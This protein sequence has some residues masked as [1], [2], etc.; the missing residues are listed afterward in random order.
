MWGNFPAR[1]VEIMQQHAKSIVG[2]TTT[3]GLAVGLMAAA[4]LH[5]ATPAAQQREDDPLEPTNQEAAVSKQETKKPD[6][7]KP[8]K[9]KSDSATPERGTIDAKYR[10]Q[11]EHLFKSDAAW[12]KERKAIVAGFKEIEACKGKL[13][14]GNKMVKTCLDRVFALRQSLEKLA[15][16]A[17]RRYDQ[18]TR[19]A[20][21]QGMKQVTEKVYTDYLEVTSFLQPELLSLPAQRL[22][23]MIK[24]KAFSDYDQFLRDILRL[25]PHILSPPEE[26]L[27]ASASLM[28]D[29]GY[30]TYSTFSGADLTFP[31]V[32]DAEGN[33]VQLTQALFT[34]YR[35]MADRRVRKDTFEA[36][37]STYKKYR[38][39]LASLLGSQINANI[40]YAKA[41]KY[42]SALEASLDANN[43][44]TAVYHNMV[45]AVN[46]HLPTLHRYLKLRQELLG[47]KDLYYYDMYPP[48]VKEV[49]LKFSYDEGR[50]LLG[51][52]L[53]PMGR[54]Y[55]DAIKKGMSPESGWVDVYPNKGK[56]S[57]AYMDGSA[58][59][60]HPFVLLNY[61]DNYNSVS[62]LAHEMGHAMHSYYSNKNQ[63]FAKADYSIFV[64]EVASTLNEAL[65]M[66]HMLAQV[67]DP[68]KRLYLLG[69]Q[70][71]D[72]RQTVFR[73]SMF[74][75]F[76][77]AL[78]QR[79]EKKEPLTSDAISKIYLEIA[80]KYYGHDKGI[81][82]VDDLYG[83]EW[84]YV[85]HFYYN[86]Y[87]FQ[88]VTGMTAATAL[89][90]MIL[91]DKQGAKA[92]ERYVNH[93]LKKGSSDYSIKLLK[94]AGVDLT[95]TK[96]YDVAMAV[97]SRALA[98]AE[99]LVKQRKKK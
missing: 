66:S 33:D 81:V 58:Y 64:A 7:K 77:L 1:Q 51:Q 84:A 68:E 82:T 11:T 96:P 98:E 36:F 50:E 13:K 37:F 31:S 88:Y 65:L 97:F 32:K 27:L 18:D 91:D 47:L 30:N 29:I 5:C 23:R 78:Y 4:L 14:R 25:K 17:H 35:A 2:I 22:R 93:M 90:E 21:Y 39:T 15:N 92:R 28:R 69:E 34:K 41:R 89:A 10:W 86:Y 79:A 6:K 75:E 49:E 46:K 56:R 70:M 95:T 62:T 85:P 16:Y 61:L 76:E 20:K 67:E 48:I 72:F 57:G 73:Q 71:E 9:K 3:L 63:P 74:A 42:D 83:M 44:P 80:R 55:L 59:A 94:N 54:D 38:N 60:V 8:E 19:V 45:K 53:A 12:D 99:K 43:I 26:K 52:A 40:V 24:D 87:V